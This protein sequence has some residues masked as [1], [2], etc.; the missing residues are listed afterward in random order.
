MLFSGENPDLG[1]KASVEFA[2]V[3]TIPGTAAATAAN[4]G[5]IF[6]ADKSYKVIEVHEIHETAGSDGGAVTLDITK[7]SGT[8][9]PAA[10]VSI[11]DSGTFNLKGTANTVQSKRASN[12]IAGCLV[13]GQRLGL[14][15]AGTLTAV[16]GL[17]VTV[18]LKAVET[19]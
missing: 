1:S 4:Y 2:L 7:D 6:T 16:A 17:Q 15:D 14:K 12:G 18:V 19:C 5:S 10:G 9:A 3:A 11:F 13:R 8:N